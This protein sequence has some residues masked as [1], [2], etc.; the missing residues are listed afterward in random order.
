[1]DTLSIQGMEFHAFH[2]VDEHEKEHGNDF[3]V[4][5]FIHSDLSKAAKSDDFADAINYARIHQI[6][7]EVMMANSVNL[8]EHL[9]FQIG[10]KIS[11]EFELSD[12]QVKVRKLNPPVHQKTKFTEASM[13]WP[14]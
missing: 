6:V 10:T 13:S 5:V 1:M 2:G 12:F 4:D 14:R 8:I 7:S 11:G 3:E 9:A